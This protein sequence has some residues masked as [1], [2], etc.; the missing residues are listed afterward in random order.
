MAIHAH[1]VGKAYGSRPSDVLDSP[2]WRFWMDA[3]V[4]AAGAAF[5]RERAEDQ[6]RSGGAG[7]ATD[8]ERQDLVDAQDRRAEQRER[9]DGQPALDDQLDALRGDD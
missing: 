4:R 1:L 6:R 9:Q 2:A 5:E 7:V 8:R 3:K